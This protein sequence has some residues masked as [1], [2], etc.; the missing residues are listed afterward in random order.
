MK[1]KIIFLIFI[2]SLSISFAEVA[3]RVDLMYDYLNFGMNARVQALGNTGIISA[4]GPEAVYYNPALLYAKS[5]IKPFLF[6]YNPMYFDRN[7]F[8]GFYH[9]ALRNRKT[10][11]GIGYIGDIIS[12]I[13]NRTAKTDSPSISSIS[14]STIVL[15][16]ARKIN[17]RTN[18]GFNLNLHSDNYS[19][20]T[21][22]LGNYQTTY[23]FGYFI[24]LTK[25]VAVAATYKYFTDYGHI[26]SL[27]AKIPFSPVIVLYTVGNYGINYG[28]GLVSFKFGLEYKYS[29]SL[30][31]QGGLDGEN[32][33]A[34]LT[35]KLKNM[36]IGYGLILNTLGI[37]HNVSIEF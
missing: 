8:Y 13:E 3:T 30:S 34:G 16:M 29:K 28:D 19:T 10:K 20:L 36:N 33:S 35:S 9:F 17:L 32:I 2:L 4:E 15:S 25:K 31:L 26:V 22:G 21:N 5:N 7:Y 37:R 11:M 23:S 14:H 24:Q 6:S 1:T 18:F 27:G 12:G